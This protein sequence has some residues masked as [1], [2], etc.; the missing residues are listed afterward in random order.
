MIEPANREIALLNAAL[1]LRPEER[2]AYIEQACAGDLA[3][4]RQVEGLLQAHDQAEDFLT[5]RTTATDVKS[6]VRLSLPVTEKPGDKIGHYKLLQQIGEGGCGVVYMA[7]QEHP[8]RRRVAIKVIKLGMDTKE[9]IA[10]FEAERQALALMD[11]PNI[12]KVLDAGATATGRPYFVMELVRGIK[13]TELCDENKL[14]TEE[15]LHL[16][17][18]VC[19]AIQHAHQKGVIHRD[20]KPSNILVTINDGVPLPKVIDFGIA[21]ATAGRLTDQTLFTAFEQ[22]IG[23][24]AY[25]SPEQAVMTSLDIDTRS[26]IYSLGV[27]LYELLTGRTPFDQKEL[28][29]AGLDEMRRTI[30]EEEPPRPSTRLSVLAAEALTTTARQRHTD[31]PRLLHLVRG[32]LDWIVMK[33]LEKDRGRRYETANGL[34]MDIQRYLRDEPIA[35]RPPSKL[36]RLSKLARRNKLVLTATGATVLALVVGALVS[37]LQ[38]VRASRAEAVASRERDTATRAQR[39]AEAINKFLTEDVLLQA[40]PEKNAPEATREMMKQILDRASQKLEGDSEPELE[41]TLRVAL[42]ETYRQLGHWQKAETHFRRAVALRRD[43]L[44][45][46]HLETLLA[47]K[48]LACLLAL[49]MNQFSAKNQELSFETWQGLKGLLVSSKKDQTQLWK[50]A[51]STQAAYL[52][53]MANRGQPEKAAQL[54]R[55]NVTDYERVLGVNDHE[56]ITA[57][58]DMGVM[59]EASGLFAQAEQ[60]YRESFQRFERNGFKDT[61]DGFQAVNNLAWSRFLQGDTVGAEQMFREARSRAQQVFDPDHPMILDLQHRLTRVLIDQRKWDEAEAMGRQTLD[62]RRLVLTSINGRTAY[63][64]IV[65]GRICFERGKLDQAE[66]LFAE[67]RSVF[68]EYYNELPRLTATAEHWL[69]AIHLARQD[70]VKAEQL[71]A[72]LSHWFLAPTIQMSP[73]E[74]RVCIEHLVTLYQALNKPDKAAAW[75]RKLSELPKTHLDPSA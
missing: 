3:L 69:G 58:H 70:Y 17:I 61:Y 46:Q 30:R 12:A 7:E 13:I 10:R 63:S 21:K 56:T 72:P 8:V 71:M 4:R 34:A 73:Q 31:A 44:G 37:T 68:R 26:D 64:M 5:P 57:W 23:T 35:A 65:L 1:E 29:A 24:P 67:A 41:A 50:A 15:R 36:Y 48:Q 49:D 52:W 53:E 51:L 60:A 54:K 75:Q 32:D 55:E 18:Q 62:T 25:M 38:A 6:T 59:L 40:S 11:H 33:A 9:V 39:H 19:H 22:F 45:P 20:I 47:Q 66:S 14:S 74:R 16:F 27:L 2:A 28:L 43:T 42:G